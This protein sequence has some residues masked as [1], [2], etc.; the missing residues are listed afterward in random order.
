MINWGR[1]WVL[2]SLFIA[3]LYVYGVDTLIQSMLFGFIVKEL[4]KTGPIQYVAVDTIVFMELQDIHG[5]MILSY[6]LVSETIHN[7]IP[8]TLFH[9]RFVSGELNSETS[10]GQRYKMKNSKGHQVEDAP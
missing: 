9:N 3:S 5:C 8:D 2:L 10:I 7:F 1:D 4:Y 6:S